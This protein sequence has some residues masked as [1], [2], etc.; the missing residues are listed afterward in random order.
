MSASNNLIRISAII[1][2]FRN[3]YWYSQ[4]KPK[5]K[6]EKLAKSFPFHFPSHHPLHQPILIMNLGKT[7][8]YFSC[9]ATSMMMTF[10]VPKF[11]G[12]IKNFSLRKMHLTTILLLFVTVLAGYSVFGCDII[13]HLKSDTDKKFDAQIIAPN[14][15]KSDKWVY[16]C[17][18]SFKSFMTSWEQKKISH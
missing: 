11:Q 3:R 7:Y 4:M 1:S 2:S 5:D 17:Y 18:I 9:S 10:G 16:F 12:D 15:K 14:G 13:V 6:S 8:E